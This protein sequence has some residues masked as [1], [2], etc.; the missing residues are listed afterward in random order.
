MSYSSLAVADYLVKRQKEQGRT[1]TPMQLIKLVYICHGWNLGVNKEPLIS[2]PI[3]AW[4]Y[5]PVIRRLYSAVKG[6]GSNPVTEIKGIAQPIELSASEK[7]LI[8]WVSDFYGKF[9][10]I[11]LSQMTHM[12]N[13]PWEITKRQQGLNKIIS[14]DLIEEFYAR[15]AETRGAAAVT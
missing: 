2:E 7:K 14:N 4:A 13:T 8:D 15:Q 3:E 10:G 9:S 5:G 1:L 11:R 12:P 6:Y